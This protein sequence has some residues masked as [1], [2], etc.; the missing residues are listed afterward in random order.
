MRLYVKIMGLMGL[1]L[2]NRSILNLNL[3]AS[4]YAGNSPAEFLEY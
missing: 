2:V 4:E 1:F 3:K